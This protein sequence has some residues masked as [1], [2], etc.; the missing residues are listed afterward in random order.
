MIDAATLLERTLTISSPSGS[1]V[2]V[3]HFLV[4]Q[5]GAF[6][7]EAF[8]D[9]AG[10]A[11]GRIGTGP[12]GVYVLGHIDTVPGDIPV[13]VEGGALYG[14]GAVDAKGPFCAAVA[15]AASLSDAVKDALT[16]TLIGAVEEE[17]PT[18]KGARYA[19]LTYPK[20]DFVI[21]GEPSGW[22]ALTLGYKG[23][24]VLKLSLEKPNFHSAGDDTTA[25][26]DAVTCWGR[27]KAWAEGVSGTG[28]D[29][30]Q[31]ALQSL[32]TDSDGLT[33]RAQ[34]V[35][36]LRL[37][38][39][40]PPER[41]E[42]ELL[43]ALGSGFPG[44]RAE[45]LGREQPYRGPK[46]TALTRAFRVAIRAAGGVPRFK[47]KTGTAD[48]NVVAPHW[49]VPML[50]YGPG[51]SALDHTPHEHVELAELERAVGVLAATFE[52]LAFAPHVRANRSG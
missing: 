52:G 35:I 8:V 25:A 20:P 19:L 38:P 33:Q 42:G 14:R 31:A 28:F 6:C 27:V 26:E 36:G 23:R 47:L 32:N 40:W 15:A 30:V 5:M 46:D 12:V 51:D 43:A 7:D 29:R 34:A 21:V 13:R 37:P 45:V 10:N 11:V 3:A 1:E 9:A 48:M 17:A 16:L 50:A 24:L 2:G 39:A 4:S 18:S 22:D 49:N 44:L 41:A